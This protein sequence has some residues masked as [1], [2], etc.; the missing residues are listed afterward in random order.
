VFEGWLNNLQRKSKRDKPLSRLTRA[1]SEKVRE[2]TPILLHE[3][4]P[5]VIRA[6]EKLGEAGDPS[7]VPALMNALE[8]VVDVQSPQWRE[9]AIALVQALEKI[10]DRRALPLLYRLENVRGIGLIPAIRHAIA[11]IEPQTSLLRPGKMQ[12]APQ[13]LLRPAA[14]A[15]HN[16]ATLMR[17]AEQD[18]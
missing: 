3:H 2:W 9:A 6:A 8:D 17:P 18:A 12:D 16:P 5:N 7:A 11:A 13:T 14:S 4:A 10:G 15:E 1:E